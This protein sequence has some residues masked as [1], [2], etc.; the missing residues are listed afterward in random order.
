MDSKFSNHCISEK[1]RIRGCVSLNNQIFD[2]IEYLYTS[3]CKRIIQFGS[4]FRQNHNVASGI[5][6]RNLHFL[7][8]L[9][10]DLK[11]LVL[12]ISIWINISSKTSKQI[13]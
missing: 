13:T 5:L 4:N 10:F 9:H 8:K 11:R 6:S 1:I 12:I 3:D 2:D 7:T